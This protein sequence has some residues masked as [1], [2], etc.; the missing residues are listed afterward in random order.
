MGQATFVKTVAARLLARACMAA[1]ITLTVL[2]A[3][4]AGAD[5]GRDIVRVEEDWELVIARPVP[6]NVAPQVTT[7]MSPYSYL[8]SIRAAFTLNPGHPEAAT[9]GGL[10]LQIWHNNDPVVARSSHIGTRL[11]HANE[12]ITWTQVMEINNGRITFSVVNGRSE[13][14]GEFGQRATLAAGINSG[15][16][17]LNQ[18]NFGVSLVNSGVSG[19]PPLLRLVRSLTVVAVRQ[20]SSRG[21]VA[22][23][24]TP[25]LVFAY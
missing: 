6:T 14:W 20:Y 7:I 9:A 17:N 18:Y 1:A 13:T 19:A 8:G 25:L 10:R 11:D 3:W 15:L 23:E 24:T 22:E 21:L 5:N 4:A 16:V 12:T 2:A